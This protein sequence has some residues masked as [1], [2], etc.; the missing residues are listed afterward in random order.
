[1]SEKYILVTMDVDGK[2][3][4]IARTERGH[5]TATPENKHLLLQIGD[6]LLDDCLIAGYTLAKFEGPVISAE[7]VR[8][9]F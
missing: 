9:I 2:G 4:R 3:V 6:A 8:C 7:G 1:M 5:V